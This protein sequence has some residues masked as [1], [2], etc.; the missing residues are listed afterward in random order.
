MIAT[1]LNNARA[2]L[3]L[4]GSAPPE[5]APAVPPRA[6]ADIALAP[7]H[8]EGRRAPDPKPQPAPQ[9]QRSSPS[10]DVLAADIAQKR[11]PESHVAIDVHLQALLAAKRARSH[12]VRT[13]G[14]ISQASAGLNDRLQQHQAMAE[15]FALDD[16]WPSAIRQLKEARDVKS[17]SFY[18]STI[19]ARLRDFEARYKE[20]RDQEKNG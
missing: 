4:G 15:K 17:A 5:P 13:G 9:V 10:L 11:W 20:E 12:R 7:V 6:V 18:V 3:N 16:A 14:S 2:P 1:P 19:S 8:V